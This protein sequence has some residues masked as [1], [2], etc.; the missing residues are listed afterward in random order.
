MRLSM[1]ACYQLAARV[2]A[3]LG[4]WEGMGGG[5]WHASFA[6][7][8]GGSA[9]GA[10]RQAAAPRAAGPLFT[11]AN[12]LCAVLW[13]AGFTLR[14]RQAAGRQ[15]A[16]REAHAQARRATTADDR[17]ID[18][19]HPEMERAA[20]AAVNPLPTMTPPQ[21]QRGGVLRQWRSF[22]GSPAKHP[23]GPAA[24]ASGGAA[25]AVAS[26]PAGLRCV[27]G[28]AVI[29]RELPRPLARP[30]NAWR[31]R[32]LSRGPPRRALQSRWAPPAAT[33]TTEVRHSAAR[34]CWRRCCAAR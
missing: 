15:A 5:G 14:G 27:F 8:R 28:S 6:W 20:S 21:L 31:A 12:A 29:A 32:R 26:L 4:T 16:Q 1:S 24:R 2:Y 7:R 22:A 11:C 3:D 25:A 34:S 19:S 10:V 23:A 33:T 9:S 13:Q 30:L 18:H 17:S